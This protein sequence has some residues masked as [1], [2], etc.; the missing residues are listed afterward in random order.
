MR[1]KKILKICGL[2]S[3]VLLLAFGLAYTQFSNRHKAVLKNNLLY[4]LGLSDAT[5]HI[6]NESQ[7]YVMLSPTFMIDDIYKSMQ[8][9]AG[10]R[11]IQISRDTSM[12]W[13]T[14]FGVEALDAKTKKRISNDFICHTNF[15]FNDVRY[16]DGLGLKDRI[17][18]QFPRMASLSHGMESFHLPAGFGIPMRGN[19]LLEV[20][21]QALNHNVKDS[22][23]WVK[24]L[25]SVEYSKAAL[26]P[27]RV[28]HAFIMLPYDEKDPYREP[29]DPSRNYCIPV[30]TDS[31]DY[32]DAKGRKLS[33]HWV[34]PAG[35]NTYRCKV[36]DQLM[37]KDSL[38]LHASAI[39]VHPFA[40]SITLFDKTKNAAVFTSS[41]VNFKNRIGIESIAPFTSE[42][43]VWLY[44]DHEYEVV[45]E[46][47]NTTSVKQDMMGSMFLFF[48]D[49]E[50]DARMD[51]GSKKAKR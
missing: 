15:D 22:T 39:H 27:L 35:K 28:G 12:I 36:N 32:C 50:L 33:G 44:K 38:R 17:G 5:W 46:V 19:D 34:V 14:G 49:S 16:Y 48:Y 47:N 31:H 43:G 40:T 1:V 23:I 29:L 10:S 9:P 25:V 18:K 45:L 30:T 37:I 26:K 24:H 42:Q 8:G 3:L 11:M 4:R 51:P 20:T 41:I 2:V 21:T 13:F 7:K 6:G